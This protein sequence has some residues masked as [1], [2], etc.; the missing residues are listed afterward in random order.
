MSTILLDM[1]A[2][3]HGALSQELRQNKYRDSGE[4]RNNPAPNSTGNDPPTCI[5]GEHQR[6]QKRIN[7]GRSTPKPKPNNEWSP[8]VGRN[9]QNRCDNR[10]NDRERYGSKERGFRDHVLM[11]NEM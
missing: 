3:Q 1:H 4:P 5:C 9:N 8:I 10:S 7:L 11:P 2:E 6:H